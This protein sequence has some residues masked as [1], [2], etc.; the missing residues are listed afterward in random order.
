MSLFIHHEIDSRKSHSEFIICSQ[1]LTSL[2]LVMLTIAPK[3]KGAIILSLFTLSEV[4]PILIYL[5][6]SNGNAHLNM[7]HFVCIKSSY[8]IEFCNLFVKEFRYQQLYSINHIMTVTL[9]LQLFYQGF[10][11]DHLRSSWE[12]LKLSKSIPSF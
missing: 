6:W 1:S 2:A 5:S 3:A 8:T 7:S 11:M 12:C 9:W 10:S 4:L